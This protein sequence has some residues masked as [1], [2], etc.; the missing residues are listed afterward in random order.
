MTTLRARGDILTRNRLGQPAL[1]THGISGDLP[2]VLVKVVEADDLALVRQ[3]LQAQEYWRVKAL[4]ADVVVLNEHAT[5]YLDEVHAGAV[6]AAGRRGV[7]HL[8]RSARRHLPAACRRARGRRAR[9]DRIGGGGGPLGRPRRAVRAARPAGGRGGAAPRARVRG[10]RRPRAARN[11]RPA[12]AGHAQR[13]RR[14]HRGRTRV[15]HRA[16]GRRRDAGAVVQ[17]PGESRLRHPGHVIRGVVHLVGEQP[18][19]P[20]H[21]VRQRPGVRC[22]RRGDLRARR[23]DRRHLGRR[24][25][26]RRAGDSRTAGWCDTAPA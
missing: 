13:R 16:R 10:P 23:P 21:P 6:G 26:G 7:E 9:A 19:E 20:P 14:L 2:I 17:H 25:P 11:H 15:R 5:D 22:H 18:R 12:A 24:R 8:A 3:V 1:W 4:A